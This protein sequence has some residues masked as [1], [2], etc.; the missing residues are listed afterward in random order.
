MVFFKS[1]KYA[2]DIENNMLLSFL[3]VGEADIGWKGQS[4]K[5]KKKNCGVFSII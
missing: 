3:L 5:L 1:N 2:R 4:L